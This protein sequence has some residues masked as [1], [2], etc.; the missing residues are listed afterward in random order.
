MVW[1]QSF[2]VVLDGRGTIFHGASSRNLGTLFW[3][4]DIGLYLVDLPVS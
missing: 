4:L 1:A 2:D 3:L